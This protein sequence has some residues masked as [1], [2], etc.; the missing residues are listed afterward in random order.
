METK[1]AKLLR[2]CLNAAFLF[3]YG[4]LSIDRDVAAAAAAAAVRL[5]LYDPQPHPQPFTVI[6]FSKML[7]KF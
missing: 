6:L 3:V 5:Q 1:G 2:V 4:L 7:N